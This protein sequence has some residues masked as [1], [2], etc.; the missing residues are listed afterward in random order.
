MINVTFVNK[1][2]TNSFVQA[3]NLFIHK[4]AFFFSKFA[5]C[6]S[7]LDLKPDTCGYRMNEQELTQFEQLCEQC[8]TNT[9]AQVRL[10]VHQPDPL[11]KDGFG[12]EDQAVSHI[13]EGLHEHL[14]HSL[15]LQVLKIYAFH[16]RGAPTEN[17]HEHD[18]RPG[19][20]IADPI[21]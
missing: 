3:S 12:R 8:C 20:E 16:H 10:L 2:T 6:L 17:V 9:N 11:V 19:Q 18:R 14:V 1:E 5:E 21:D 7:K 4:S 15:Q 13:A